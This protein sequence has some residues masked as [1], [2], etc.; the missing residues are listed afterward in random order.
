MQ[1]VLIIIN[2]NAPPPY[3]GHVLMVFPPA[4]IDMFLNW[5]VMRRSYVIT[6]M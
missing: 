3:V 6:V 4:L 5:D 1:I 2:V